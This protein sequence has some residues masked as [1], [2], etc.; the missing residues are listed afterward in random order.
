MASLGLWMETVPTRG[1][2]LAFWV[3]G[4]NYGKECTVSH[5]TALPR[6]RRP[7]FENSPVTFVK[8]DEF[9]KMLLSFRKL[10]RADEAQYRG[11]LDLDTG[12]RFLI[13]REELLKR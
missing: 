8:R 11:L 6:K 5:V 3:N 13:D 10:V 12:R 9:C 7:S 4:L 2:L 1:S